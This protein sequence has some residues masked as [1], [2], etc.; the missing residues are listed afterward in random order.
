MIGGE[1]NEGGEPRETPTLSV[2]RLRGPG[3]PEP[4]PSWRDA[5]GLVAVSSPPSP[6]FLC[7]LSCVCVWWGGEGGKWNAGLLNKLKYFYFSRTLEGRSGGEVRCSSLPQPLW[8]L[9]T[10]PSS[11]VVAHRLPSLAPSASPAAA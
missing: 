4:W 1:R 11:E 9:A 2:L 5:P 3:D 10:R 7:A 8:D 6:L